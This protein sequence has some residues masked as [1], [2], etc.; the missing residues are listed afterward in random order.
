MIIHYRT[1]ISKLKNQI[2]IMKSNIE[3]FNME[4]QMMVQEMVGKV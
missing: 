1:A 3:N 4:K 2:N